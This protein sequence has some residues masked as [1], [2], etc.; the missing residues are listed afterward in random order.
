MLA[1]QS[2]W[3][4]DDLRGEREVETLFSTYWAKPL[5]FLSGLS[6]LVIILMLCIPIFKRKL[7]K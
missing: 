3:Q 2:Q 1:T 5:N 4:V 6:L 7:Q